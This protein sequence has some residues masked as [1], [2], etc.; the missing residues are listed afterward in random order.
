[1]FA[2]QV[3]LVVFL[4]LVLHVQGNLTSISDNISD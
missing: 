3:V 2:R 1:M 4:S